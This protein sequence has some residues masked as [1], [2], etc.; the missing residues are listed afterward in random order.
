MSF[1]LLINMKRIIKIICN[2]FKEKYDGKK[3][4]F[5]LSIKKNR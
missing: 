5:K 3:H 4:M 2:Y 1:F